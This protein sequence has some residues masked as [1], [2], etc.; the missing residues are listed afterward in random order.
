MIVMKKLLIF[1]LFVSLSTHSQTTRTLCLDHYVL[2]APSLYQY[3]EKNVI[4]KLS[5]KD[6]CS[7]SGVETTKGTIVCI[8]AVE[9]GEYT[10]YELMPKGYLLISDYM[11]LI[12]NPQHIPGVFNVRFPAREYKQEQ[13]EVLPQT[14]GG[15]EWRFLFKNNKYYLIDERTNW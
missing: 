15:K 13:T 4:G 5:Y 1:F 11:F 2:L 3:I 8:S 14:D 6:R 10:N 12:Y 9:Q 7:I